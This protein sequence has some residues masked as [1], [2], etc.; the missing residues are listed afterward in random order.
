MSTRPASEGSSSDTLAVW[1]RSALSVYPDLPFDFR[2]AVNLNIFLNT[3]GY[4]LRMVKSNITLGGKISLALKINKLNGRITTEE[5]FAFSYTAVFKALSQIND[6]I[7]NN[8]I[9]Y[10]YIMKQLHEVTGTGQPLNIAGAPAG[11]F[12]DRN[13]I[14]KAYT[15]N[16]I[17]KLLSFSVP[18]KEPSLSTTLGW[19]DWFNQQLP[20]QQVSIDQI[21]VLIKL[22]AEHNNLLVTVEREHSDV[23]SGDVKT[24]PVTISGR[25]ATQLIEQIGPGIEKIMTWRAAQYHSLEIIIKELD[26]PEDRRYYAGPRVGQ[27]SQPPHSRTFP[28]RPDPAFVA[29]LAIGS[30]YA[31][32]QAIIPNIEKL[33]GA[34]DFSISI[35]SVHIKITSNNPQSITDQQG[36]Y[37]LQI[38]AGSIISFIAGFDFRDV[39]VMEFYRNGKMVAS[40]T[41]RGSH[42]G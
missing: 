6:I 12:Y 13:S 3:N 5:L 41:L 20:L 27:S 28:G 17:N 18:S 30:P 22:A 14:D 40:I 32:F 34:N 1:L 9:I 4:Y 31:N 10:M 42:R 39:L 19:Y 38:L 25:G 15:K 36:K 21:V 11:S 37:F 26:A 7:P 16:N 24:T 8:Y 23:Y 35:S 2:L 33:A 29:F